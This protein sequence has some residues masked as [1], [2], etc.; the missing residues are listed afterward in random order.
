MRNVT[1][2]GVVTAL[3]SISHIG[4]TRGVNAELRREKVITPDGVQDIPIVSGNG[5]R[6]MLRDR[7][8][9]HMCRALGYGVD[10]ETGEV[11]GLSLPAFH[12]LFSGGTLTSDAGR[13]LDVASARRIRDLIPLV[14][15]FG[16]AMGNQIMPGKLTVGKLV[17]LCA[18]TAGIIP[19]RLRE[20]RPPLSIWDLLQQEAYTRRDDEKNETL[21]VLVAPQTRALLEAEQAARAAKRGTADDV[22]REIGQHQQMRYYVETFAAGTEFYWYLELADAT[23]IEFEA[24]LTALVEFSRRPVIGGKGA[25]GHGRVAVHFDRWIEIDPRVSTTGREIDVPVGARY[26]DHLATRANDIR[27]ELARMA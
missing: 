16:G 6:G 20:T 17:P 2:E 21:R 1:F 13:G 5:A 7:G 8:M 18:E 11:R 26:A 15:V 25:I 23:D 22:D 19:E 12:F 14:G 3:S 24:L 9:L 4:D 10:E 27:A